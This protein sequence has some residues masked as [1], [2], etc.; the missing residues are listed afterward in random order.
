[1]AI[2]EKSEIE[3]PDK[4]VNNGN[5]NSDGEVEKRVGH[6]SFSTKLKNFI[7]F[8]TVEPFLFCFVLPNV[9]TA[10]AVQQFNME[11]ACRADLN[12]SE[13]VCTQALSG[14]F[15]ENI[16]VNALGEAQTLVA[17]MTS[18]KQPLQ[19]AIP[20]LVTLFVGAW[21]D[22][23]GNRKY[24]MLIPIFGEFIAAIGLIFTTYFFL[25][26][27]LWLAGLIQALPTTFTGGFPI[28]LLGS[29]SYM[30]DVTTVE[31][32]TF[33]MGCLGVIVTLGI[34]LATSISGV[35]TEQV[36]Y[37][38]VFGTHAFFCGLGFVYVYFRIHDIKCVKT[39]EPFL[40]K[41][42]NFF[43]PK[44][45]WDTLSLLFLTPKKELIQIWSIIWAHLLVI[46][47]VHGESAV[48]YLYTLKKFNMDLVEYSL[49]ST[50]FV[51][52]GIAG[53]ATAAI[54]LS[55]YLKLHDDLLGAIATASKVLSSFMYGLAPNKTWFY[56]APVIDFFG[57]TGSTVVRS[58]GTKV[59][60][61]DEVGKMCSL[62]G[63][64]EAILPIIYIP[65]YSTLYAKTLETLPGA[66][67]LL[68]GLMTLPAIFIFM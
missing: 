22:R 56:I 53:T 64:V 34:P 6:T 39:E 16:T 31:S 5:N 25:E 67:Y 47:P 40:Q 66:F 18:W 24:L 13:Y 41:I 23:T 3:L 1:M 2:K 17:E 37:Y 58:L 30:A 19:S 38:G 10:I 60:Q 42:K 63:V 35:L 51:L 59:V 61:P 26:W 44:N 36:G 54:V 52:L 33:R 9:I 46:G 12:Y 62:L 21:S 7:L 28:A 68:G 32:R 55:K 65:I 4:K 14:D 20:A 29:Y 15:S 8:F 43:H 11:K 45:A 48:L 49:F 50:Y 57:N 27:P